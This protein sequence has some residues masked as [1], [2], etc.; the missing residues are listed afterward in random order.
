M[1][2]DKISVR[3]LLDLSAAFD[4]I[5]HRILLSGNCLLHRLCHTPVVSIISAGQKSLR[6]CQPFC[7]LSFFG[8]WSSTGLSVGP[9]LFALYT[10]PLSDIIQSSI[11][12]LQMT[13][14]CKNQPHQTMYKVLHMTRNK[15]QMTWTHGCATISSNLTRMKLRPFS[16]WHPLCLLIA[17]CHQPLMVLTKL[18]SLTKLGSWG[19]SLT[20]T[21]LWKNT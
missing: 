19:S 11:S 6:C 16:S 7:F 18:Y 13:P 3:H 4:T 8:A 15:A 21:S 17:Y 12:S 1:D 2:K 20:L 9:V 14:N 10:T 5:D